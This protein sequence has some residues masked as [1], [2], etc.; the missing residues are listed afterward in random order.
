MI[1]PALDQA[2]HSLLSQGSKSEFELIKQLQQPPYEI[3]SAGVFADELSLFQTHFILHNALYRL[4]DK[5][6]N[7][8]SYDIDILPTKITILPFIKA[9]TT[10]L[11]TD[12]ER[13]IAKLRAYY[14][15]WANFNG[16]EKGDVLDLLDDFWTRFS[17]FNYSSVAQQ[18][19]DSAL[20]NMEF[21]QLPDMAE[22]KLKYKQLCNLHHPDKGG[23]QVEFQKIQQAYQVLKLKLSSN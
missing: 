6:L 9:N 20:A 17:K 14:L 7:E 12:V 16:T 18:E 1:N 15:D 10:E 5:G 22:L 11:T 13:D 8:Q 4:R 21:S 19:L 23:S 2:I 3:F